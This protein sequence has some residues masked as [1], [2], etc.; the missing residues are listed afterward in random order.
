MKTATKT[1]VLPGGRSLFEVVDDEPWQLYERVR[2]AGGVAWDD[3]ANGWLVVSYDLIK[4]MGHAD[5]IDWQALTT[6]GDDPD[7]G[8]AWD[9]WTA[10]RG[11]PRTLSLREGEDHHVFHRW[12]LKALSPKV[13]Q[14]WGETLIEPICHRQIDRFAHLGKAELV[15]D[16]SERITPPV[17]AAVLGLPWEDDDWFSGFMEL[18]AASNAANVF[19]FRDAPLPPPEALERGQEAMRELIAMVMPAIDRKRDGVGEDFISMIWRDADELFGE[20]YSDEDVAYSVIN[21]FIAGGSIAFG[22]NNLIYLTLSHPELHDTL[23]TNDR[24]VDNIVEE[25][26]RLYTPGEYRP[27]RAMRDLELGGVT[28]RKGELVFAI[29]AAGNR[30]PLHY[31]NPLELDLERRAPRNHL[32]FYPGPRTCPGQ[33]LARYELARLLRVLLERLP[34]LRLDPDAEP[35]RYTGSTARTWRPLNVLFDV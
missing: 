7:A 30:D 11:G 34:G 17:T 3:R 23:L 28:I 32:G 9:D 14:R 8:M 19:R 13:L 6:A 15:R 2:D 10:L 18:R 16:Y 1:P 27:R 12:W 22:A 20:G 26:L 21:A 25:G 24:A 33:G 29:S 4:Q 31:A 35:P 5:D